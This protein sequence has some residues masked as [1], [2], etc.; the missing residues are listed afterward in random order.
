LFELSVQERL[1]WLDETAVAVRFVGAA[2]VGVGVGVEVGVGVGVGVPVGTV[3][4][5]TLL[6]AAK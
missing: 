1:I 4:A 6:L 3:K 2:G 5:Y